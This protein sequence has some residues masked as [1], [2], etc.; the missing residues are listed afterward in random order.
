MDT[1]LL[2]SSYYVKGLWLF[3]VTILRSDTSKAIESVE[4]FTTSKILVVKENVYG[5][6]CSISRKLQAFCLR[7]RAGRA[8]RTASVC[9]DLPDGRSNPFPQP[10]DRVRRLARRAVGLGSG[11]A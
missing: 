11:A 10:D 9:P 7:R 3:I 2:Y 6:S 8:D 5:S 1:K 4:Q